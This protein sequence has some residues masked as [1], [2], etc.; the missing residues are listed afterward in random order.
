MKDYR[1]KKIDTKEL[2]EI[3]K[4]CMPLKNSIEKTGLINQITV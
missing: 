4:Q 3:K 2:D 1:Q